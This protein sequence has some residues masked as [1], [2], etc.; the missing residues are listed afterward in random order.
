MQEEFITDLEMLHDYQFNISFDDQGLA[1]IR[2]DEP[3]PIGGG[4]YPN[5][6]RYLSAAVGN[7]LCASLAFC[8]RKARSEPISMK[9]RVRTVLGRNDKGRLRVQSMQVTIFPEVDDQAKLERCLPLFEDFCT[10][11]AAVREG[12]DIQV[13][14]ETPKSEQ[15]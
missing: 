2:S 13:S 15:R 5:A 9:A 10:V 6:T 14:V 8:L 4:E 12:I 11:S 1:D 7:C 3:V